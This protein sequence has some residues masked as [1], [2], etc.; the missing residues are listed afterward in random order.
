MSTYNN[1]YIK[2]KLNQIKQL[3][4]HYLI[5]LPMVI[6]IIIIKFEMP[7]VCKNCRDYS[8][9]ENL[10]IYD[11]NHNIQLAFLEYLEHH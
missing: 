11:E 10:F 2:Y 9:Y 5:E 8:K 6:K 7:L 4:N 1:N 3:N